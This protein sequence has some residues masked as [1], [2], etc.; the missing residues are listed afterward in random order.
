[1]TRSI[2]VG[3]RLFVRRFDEECGVARDLGD[4]AGARARPRG[5]PRSWLRAPGSRSLRRSTD[6]R[7]G[8]RLPSSARRPASD[9]APARITR[10]AAPPA[11]ARSPRRSRAGRDRRGPAMTRRR[12]GWRLDE[13]AERA[14]EMRE[15]LAGL[16][17]ADRDDERRAAE[18]GLDL[19]RAS[20]P[21][22]RAAGMPSGMTTSRPAARSP[23]PKI[24]SISSATNSDPVCRVAP[25]ATARRMTGS[26]RAHLGSAQL[27]I[28]HER[29]V[30]HADERRQPT[31]RREIVRRVHDLM[32][33]AATDR[34]AARR[35]GPTSCSRMRAGIG[36]K[37]VSGGTAS[38]CRRARVLSVYGTR[39]GPASSA[40]S[41]T[42][43]SA[44]AAPMPERAPSSGV[45]SIATVGRAVGAT[46][47]CYHTSPGTL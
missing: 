36:T 41:A 29:A 28:A 44:T 30:V 17:R 45:T 20:A 8:S 6:T 13:L 40:R 10:S 46:E 27:G 21:R 2:C 31:R 11:A 16:E 22:R 5:H 33:G 24:S 43:I 42:T 15:V 23:G 47:G 37:R 25:R 1:M 12:S 32:P 9:T 4:R 34:C 7:A 14:D 26:K 35:R 38:R 19:G 18:R 3:E 39:S